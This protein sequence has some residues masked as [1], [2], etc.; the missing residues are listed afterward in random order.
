MPPPLFIPAHED[1]DT[2]LFSQCNTE[3]G[4]Q[5]G[6]RHTHGTQWHKRRRCRFEGGEVRGRRENGSM[7]RASGGFIYRTVI[8]GN[9]GEWC[10][11]RSIDVNYREANAFAQQEQGG[12]AH[13]RA[14]ALACL[15]TNPALIK[16]TR[17]PRVSYVRARLCLVSSTQRAGRAPDA[18][19]RQGEETRVRNLT[20]GPVFK[21]EGFR[22]STLHAIFGRSSTQAKGKLDFGT[23]RARKCG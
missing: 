13:N 9:A 20:R 14:P 22:H 19:R 21:P 23:R 11:D 6:Q 4:E 1:A 5:G 18:R 2:R 17:C 7:S 10:V 16:Q 15:R 8:T 12:G 3:G